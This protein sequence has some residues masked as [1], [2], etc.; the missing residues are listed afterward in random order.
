[1]STPS[2]GFLRRM[3]QGTAVVFLAL[4]VYVVA[5]ARRME[6]FTPIGSRGGLLPVLARG[7]HGDP[8]RGLARPGVARLARGRPAGL[9]AGARRGHAHRRRPRGAGPP[10]GR[11][12]P[13]GYCLA[14]LAFALGLLVGVGR[15][16]LAV[17]V[18]IA[19]AGS[20]GLYYVFRYWLGVHLPPSA[21]DVLRDL[22][23]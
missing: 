14:M 18:P 21:I 19:L 17:S 7:P 20:F 5:E 1:M 2:D 11:D 9:H 13:P 10:R 22:G 8:R 12:R 4:G 23:F 15:Q 16:P 6:Y 3:Y